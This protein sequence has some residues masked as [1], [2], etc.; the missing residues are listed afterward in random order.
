MFDMMAMA[1]APVATTAREIAI[2]RSLL[3]LLED[4][5]DCGDLHDAAD[6]AMQLADQLHAIE[7]HRS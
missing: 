7:K 6:I 4:A 1:G 2:A 5:I 3:H